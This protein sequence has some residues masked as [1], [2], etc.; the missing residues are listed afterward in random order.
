MNRH[1][2]WWLCEPWFWV[3]R[4][5]IAKKWIEPQR[6]SAAR[7]SH[8]QASTTYYGTSRMIIESLISIENHYIMCAKPNSQRLQNARLL[9]LSIIKESHRVILISPC[10]FWIQKEMLL[11]TKPINYAQLIPVH[12]WFI[13]LSWNMRRW[14]TTCWS[15][16]HRRSPCWPARR[17]RKRAV[18]LEKDEGRQCHR[19]VWLRVVGRSCAMK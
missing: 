10:H 8:R 13:S 1:F 12:I 3:R 17:D 19:R 2:L 4:L 14:T 9:S 7:R 5:Y 11:P 16:Y 15:T 6:K 18:S